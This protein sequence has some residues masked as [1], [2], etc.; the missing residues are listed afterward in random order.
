LSKSSLEKML[1]RKKTCRDKNLARN[2]ARLLDRPGEN[3]ASSPA[4]G[5]QPG[6]KKPERYEHSGMWLCRLRWK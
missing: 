1:A 3:L 6:E 2:L 5:R 4:A